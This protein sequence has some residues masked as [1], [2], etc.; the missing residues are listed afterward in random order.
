MTGISDSQLQLWRSEVARG[1]SPG[2]RGKSVDLVLMF[3]DEV[4]T[5]HTDPAFEAHK[6]PIN[7][8]AQ[9][10]WNRILPHARLRTL[11]TKAVMR[12]AGAPRIWQRVT[13][14]AAAVV[15]TSQRIGWTMTRFDSFTDD[16]G[17]EWL[18]TRDSPAA[19][20]AAVD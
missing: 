2:S 9:A 14:P 16:L 3:A 6:L 7:Y 8:L 10:V 1:C 19:I 11:F 20:S 4:D 15:A 5:Q 12:L 18:L 17:C 13:G